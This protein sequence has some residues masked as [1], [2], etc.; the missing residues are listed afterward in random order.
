MYFLG[1][2]I[3]Y[4]VCHILSWMSFILLVSRVYL[5]GMDNIMYALLGGSG[6]LG[7]ALP[8]NMGF[9]LMEYAYPIST[10]PP[11]DFSNVPMLLLL[12]YFAITLVSP[13]VAF[14]PIANVCV[15]D[16]LDLDGN[17][18]RTPAKENV[19]EAASGF[20]R[21][22][23]AVGGEGGTQPV[24]R[25]IYLPPLI[26]FVFACGHSS[27]A[28]MLP[29]RASASPFTLFTSLTRLIRCPVHC[30]ACRGRA[31]AMWHGKRK[32]SSQRPPKPG[33]SGPMCRHCALYCLPPRASV[34]KTRTPRFLAPFSLALL[35]SCPSRSE[36]RFMFAWGACSADDLFRSD[37]VCVFLLLL[38]RS[39]HIALC[40]VPSETHT[41]SLYTYICFVCL[42]FYSCE[43][44]L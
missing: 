16:N 38:P 43:L 42:S 33:T 20:P 4:E 35:P 18:K 37:V 6:N 32:R 11:C 8:S 34:A 14:V 21:D 7:Q 13:I 23:A 22:E 10:R 44:F 36:S 29:V 9:I 39:G 5:H 1:D 25:G 17:C 12:D 28:V 3:V 26:C 40:F 2:Q 31:A 19:D 24:T 41:H 15:C 27:F 30:A